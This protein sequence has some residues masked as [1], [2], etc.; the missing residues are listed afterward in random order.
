MVGTRV[1]SQ[2]DHL[3]TGSPHPIAQLPN[4]RSCRCNCPQHATTWPYCRLTVNVTFTVPNGVQG[5]SSCLVAK[6]LP[7]TVDS[8]SH[9]FSRIGNDKR[10]STP[11]S[12]RPQCTAPVDGWGT[13]KAGSCAGPAPVPPAAMNQA[14]RRGPGTRW[15]WA[16]ASSNWNGVV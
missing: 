15:N 4:R 12:S 16:S 13:L 10:P 7:I 8:L 6:G 14:M 1:M 9:H 11:E 3:W 2:L 5:N